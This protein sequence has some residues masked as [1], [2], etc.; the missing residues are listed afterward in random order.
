MFFFHKRKKKQF[1][2]FFFCTGHLEV[3]FNRS[4]VLSSP[5]ATEHKFRYIGNGYFYSAY[6]P[7]GA[8]QVARTAGM[9]LE[10]SLLDYQLGD[11][12]HA[13]TAGDIR[14]WYEAVAP[15]TVS[16]LGRLTNTTIGKAAAANGYQIGMVQQGV[17]TASQMMD[18][19][20]RG[21]WW[22]AVF[23]HAC[24]VGWGAILGG[25]LEQQQQ[26]SV[27]F[28]W[29]RVTQHTLAF[30]GF[31]CATVWLVVYGPSPWTVSMLC[32]C[33]VVV[34]SALSAWYKN[35]ASCIQQA[36]IHNQEQ[37]QANP[38]LR[39]RNSQEEERNHAMHSPC[40]S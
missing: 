36:D 1:Q 3:P 32:V 16:V 26:E 5:A 30:A 4:E 23:W 39:E 29:A 9:W 38:P 20:I 12:F 25:W 19:E 11:L 35:L 37:N 6:L 14:V 8:E 40:I 18:V 28:S 21:A 31:L 24:A 2:S 33:S 27:A 22:S 13:C 7:Q 17:R 10:G 15:E 34:Y